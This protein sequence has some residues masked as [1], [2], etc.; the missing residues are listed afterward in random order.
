MKF[1]PKSLTTSSEKK[2]AKSKTLLDYT[3]RQKSDNKPKSY[4]QFS[5]ILLIPLL[6]SWFMIFSSNWSAFPSTSKTT[7]SWVVIR[8]QRLIS[9]WNILMKIYNIPARFSAQLLP[10]FFM[11]ILET[12][13]LICC[14]WTSVHIVEHVLL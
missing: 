9:V 11:L 10:P 14:T 4:A 6:S 13:C 1:N 5:Y 2:C 3:Y 12:W 7:Q 8:I